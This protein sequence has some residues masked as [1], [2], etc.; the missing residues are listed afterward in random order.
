MKLSINKILIFLFSIILTTS[1]VERDYFDD[2]ETGPSISGLFTEISGSISG[3][4]V[5]ADSPYLIKD[6]IIIDSSASLK[7]EPGVE[8]YFEE[9]K[10]L[11]V[12]G[13]LEAIGQIYYRIYFLPYRNNWA[14]IKILNADSQSFFHFCTFTEI[15]SPDPVSVGSIL[16]FESNSN[17]RNC[18]FENNAAYFGGA[19]AAY[20][21]II[22]IRNVIFNLNQALNSGAAIYSQNSD[23]VLINNVFNKNKSMNP[24][25]AVTILLP[26]LTEIQNNIFYE[27]TANERLSHLLY[28]SSDS[29]NYIEQYNYIALE[30]MDPYF[31]S[32]YNFG[33]FYDSPCK[34]AGNPAEEFNDVN[35]TRNDQGA[36]GGPY[37]Y[38]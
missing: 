21:S 36:Y 34:N 12:K 35:G 7:I 30:N 23:I 28:S 6:D 17:F 10:S 14:G 16:I 25:G 5:K 11:I 3:V 33:L 19:I 22:D 15:Y 38:W 24:G 9:G 37:G 8:L 1:C 26:N 4:L 13:E 27:N 32:E 31:I 2:D 29:T 20:S 18:Y